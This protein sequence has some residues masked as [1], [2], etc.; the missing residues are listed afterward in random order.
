MQIFASNK[1]KSKHSGFT[2]LELMITLGIVGILVAIGVPAMSDVIQRAQV[3]SEAQKYVGV[4][5]LARSTAISENQA[6]TIDFGGPGANGLRNVDVFSDTDGN[7]A[8]SGDDE[9][10]TQLELEQSSL[11]VVIQSPPGSA[12][13]AAASVSFDPNGRLIGT[14]IR[15]DIENGNQNLGRLIDVNLIGRATVSEKTF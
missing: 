11:N 1:P 8:F 5:S 7:Q 9:Y 10:I 12:G 13:A 2:L 4:L 3:R 14:A 15:I 6:V